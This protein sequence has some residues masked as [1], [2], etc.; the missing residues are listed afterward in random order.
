VAILRVVNPGL[1]RE[2]YETMCAMLDNDRRHPL[3][4]IMHG[5]GEVDGTMQVA[6]IWDSEE[7][8]WRFDE[9]HLQPVLQAVDT[10]L[11]AAITA[12]ELE[13]LVTP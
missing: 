10:R 8:A 13:H 12:F 7:Y 6:Q 9:D 3:G 2:T 4:L 5:A 1:D 11:D